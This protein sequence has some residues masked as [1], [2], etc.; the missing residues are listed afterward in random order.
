MVLHNLLRSLVCREA[1]ESYQLRV[2]MNNVFLSMVSWPLLGRLGVLRQ[3]Y[4]LDSPGLRL[5]C[6]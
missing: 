4:C 2:V 5:L 1:L 3:E 6:V